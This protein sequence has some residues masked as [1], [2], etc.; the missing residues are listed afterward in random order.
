MN[1]LQDRKSNSGTEYGAVDEHNAN[2]TLVKEL[3]KVTVTGTVERADSSLP[4]PLQPNFR[5]TAHLE[6]VLFNWNF[7]HC[8][9]AA[10]TVKMWHYSDK[11]ASVRNTLFKTITYR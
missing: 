1:A 9:I 3:N 8:K 11:S 6:S 4:K 2:D 10:I 7:P 5:R